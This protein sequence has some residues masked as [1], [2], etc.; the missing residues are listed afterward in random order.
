M[1]HRCCKVVR[2]CWSPWQPGSKGTPQHVSLCT[3]RVNYC[4][5]STAAT[6]EKSSDSMLTMPNI[7]QSHPKMTEVLA[8]FWLAASAN[9]KDLCFRRTKSSA[10]AYSVRHQA[11]PS[12]LPVAYMSGNT[13]GDRARIGHVALYN[14]RISLFAFRLCS[15]CSSHFSVACRRHRLCGCVCVCVSFC[16]A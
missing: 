10:T 4:W 7:T 8:P 2:T 5:L 14:M 1:H 11:N 12:S 13:K 15:G 16:A 3:V 9:A 6:A